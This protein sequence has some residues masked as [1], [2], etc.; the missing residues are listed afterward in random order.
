MLDDDA[1]NIYTDGSSFSGPRVGEIGIVFVIVNSRGDE[2]VVNEF[3]YPGYKQATNN[4]ME[5]EACIKGLE[6]A[7]DQEALQQF[8]KIIIHTDSRY[9]VDNYQTA[10]FVWPTTRWTSRQT[11]RPILHVGQWKRLVRLLKRAYQ[12]RRSVNIKWVKGHSKDK[13]NKAADKN[14]RKSAKNPLHKPLSTV[15]VRR[16]KT[17]KSVKIGSVKMRGQRL[18]IRIFTTE[19]LTTHRLWKYKYEVISRKSKYVDN[20]DII[21]STEPLRDGHCYMV[22]LNKDTANPRITRMLN[23]I[24][25][26]ET[27]VIR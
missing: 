14:A 11:G 3:D 17:P 12:E 1:L 21:F 19:Y 24:E 7:L 15:S 2:E 27:S 23:E 20:V 9:I 16:K 13:Y 4:E 26:S 5:L 8:E 18:S 10:K 25:C 22:V 6:E